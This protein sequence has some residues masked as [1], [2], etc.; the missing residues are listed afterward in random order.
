MRPKKKN[1]KIK[2]KIKQIKKL[3]TKDNSVYMKG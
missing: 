3:E 2:N 1:K